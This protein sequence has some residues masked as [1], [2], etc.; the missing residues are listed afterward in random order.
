MWPSVQEL[1]ASRI[2]NFFK[3]SSAKTRPERKEKEG[4]Y[5]QP[6]IQ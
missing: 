2:L 4:I 3:V 6:T 5:S 1:I